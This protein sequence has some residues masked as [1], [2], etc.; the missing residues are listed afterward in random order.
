M[1]SHPSFGLSPHLSLGV[2]EDKLSV[3][4]KAL[5]NVSHRLVWRGREGVVHVNELKN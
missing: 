5:A 1:L 4:A 2:V 3:M